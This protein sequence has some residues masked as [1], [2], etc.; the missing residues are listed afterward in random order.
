M[1]L[2]LAAAAFLSATA[3]FGAALPP[4]PDPSAANLTPAQIQTRALDA[5]LI[6]QA[7]L[8]GVTREELRR[9]CTCYAQ[10]TVKAMSPAE[11]ANFRATGYFDDATRQKA[12]GFIDQCK[13]KRPF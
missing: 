6:T 3:A 10:R 2:A 9:P 13:L 4:P 5:C 12:L 8:M 1:R 7:K 11:I